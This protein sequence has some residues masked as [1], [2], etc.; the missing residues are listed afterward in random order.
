MATQARQVAEEEEEDPNTSL[1]S[2]DCGF[3]LNCD[4]EPCGDSFTLDDDI[5]ELSNAKE[6]TKETDSVGGGA[7]DEEEKMGLNEDEFKAEENDDAMR[8][9]VMGDEAKVMD[10]G[11]EYVFHAE[12]GAGHFGKVFEC[13]RKVD[14]RFFACKQLDKNQIRDPRT[15]RTEV[16]I[17]RRLTHQNILRIEEVYETPED[18]WIVTELC[19]GGDLL[20]HLM[21]R[22]GTLSETAART[23]MKQIFSAVNACHDA[24]VVHRDLKPENVMLTKKP[25][26]DDDV[27]IKVIDFGLSCI[28]DG[29]RELHRVVGSP[30]YIAPEVLSESREGYTTACDLWSTGVIFYLLLCGR[31]PFAPDDSSFVEGVV[32]KRKRASVEELKKRIRECDYSLDFGSWL[33]CSTEAC[34]LVQGLLRSRPAWRLTASEALRHAFIQIDEVARSDPEPLGAAALEALARF[35]R[36]TFFHKRLYT[37]LADT[38]TTR[39]LRVLRAE[40]ECLDHDDDGYVSVH[41]LCT[42]LK[43]RG[44]F[45]E[46]IEVESMVEACDLPED[47]YVS[48]DEFVLASVHRC[49]YLRE[50]RVDALFRTYLDATGSEPWITAESLRKHGFDD[51]V[52]ADVFD[53]CGQTKQDGRIDRNE[54]DTLLRLGRVQVR[55]EPRRPHLPTKESSMRVS[56]AADA[57]DHSSSSAFQQQQHSVTARNLDASDASN[58]SSTST[59]QQQQQQQRRVVPSK[60][61]SFKKKQQQQQTHSSTMHPGPPSKQA[62]NATSIGDTDDAHHTL[63][64]DEENGVSRSEMRE[65][66][67]HLGIS[68]KD[69]KLL[70]PRVA[71]TPR[72]D[73]PFFSESERHLRAMEDVV[74]QAEAIDKNSPEVLGRRAA[75]SLTEL[76]ANEAD[77]DAILQNHATDDVDKKTAEG[78]YL[79]LAERAMRDCRAAAIAYRKHERL[80]EAINAFREAK[81]LQFILESRGWVDDQDDDDDDGGLRGKKHHDDRA[82]QNTAGGGAWAMPPPSETEVQR[83]DERVIPRKRRNLAARFLPNPR[84][85]LAM[86]RKR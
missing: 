3:L 48:Y 27:T 6:T 69:V 72:A 57:L 82:A 29:E 40:F 28:Y 65:R 39:E 43:N 63:G 79:V 76:K 85:I 74:D 8:E 54:F 37:A 45:S 10:V 24:G 42:A 5:F 86:K 46:Q 41:D 77:L 80:S 84:R 73:G 14:G 26:T 16:A 50:D 31:P 61:M 25:S 75:N 47:H 58:F 51:D 56:F 64:E 17:M 12:I 4:F 49:R 60:E 55:Q 35:A 15:V 36:T 81:N 32:R 30:Y 44:N 2:F 11:E 66:L 70:N 22:G 18:A 1:G 21:R 62:S 71:W 33:R 68:E 13:S 23:I 20:H 67:E 59:N 9:A 19:E 52:I 78:K 53:A 38:L 7:A 34:E 83:R